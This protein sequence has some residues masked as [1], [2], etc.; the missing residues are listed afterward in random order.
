MKAPRD[1]VAYAIAL[2]VAQG[3]DWTMGEMA[4][5][6]IAAFLKAQKNAV[7]AV[8]V[9]VNDREVAP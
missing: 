8:S 1:K 2:R 6:A 3:S 7:P 5:I 4:D 9:S